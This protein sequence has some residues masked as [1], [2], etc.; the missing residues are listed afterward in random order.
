MKKRVN[1]K[2]L[3]YGIIAPVTIWLVLFLVLPYFNLFLYSFWKNGP[4]DVIREFTLEN[5]IKFFASDGGSGGQYTIL[6]DTL[7]TSLIVTLITVVI[8]FPLAYFINFIVQKAKHKQTIY[9]MAIIPLWVSYIMRA[10]AWKI[11]L[12]TNG[13]LNSFLMWLGVTDH[14]L[15]VFLYS[16][17][18]V[19]IAMVH[20]YTPYVLMPIY[21]A[22]EQIPRNLIEASKDLGCNGFRTLC[23]VIMPLAL[24]GIITGATY[25]FA[26]SMG[27]FLAPSLLGGSTT[28]TKIANIVQMQFGTS[29]NWP[30]GAAI[31]IIIL[32]FVLVLLEIT[33]HMEKRTS[34]LSEN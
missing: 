31:G 23:K 29:N 30:Y 33:S 24:P 1:K 34:K 25:S 2:F 12:G 17:V 32:L 27:D 11:I 20:I 9:M 6:L 28:S 10:Y 21:T 8:S 13:V 7:K 4:F 14:P 18:S 15:D 16:N 26:L 22:L 19:I 3:K 5:Y